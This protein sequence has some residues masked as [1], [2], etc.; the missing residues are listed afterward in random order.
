MPLIVLYEICIWIAWAIERKERRENPELYVEEDNTDLDVKDEDWNKEGIGNWFNG[1][2]NNDDDDNN[3]GSPRADG[4]GSGPAP[5]GSGG[6]SASPI[7]PADGTLTK[8]FG[9]DPY[10]ASTEKTE[11][12][13]EAESA[14]PPLTPAPGPPMAAEPVSP[15]MEMKMSIEKTED[16]NHLVLPPGEVPYSMS[17]EDA[18]GYRDKHEGSEQANVGQ[19]DEKLRPQAGAQDG[20]HPEQKGG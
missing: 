14:P 10:S 4:G 18:A 16:W 17:P 11:P 7:A 1:N 9:G 3:G 13:T 20:E 6:S 2:D 8:P 15:E 5:A 12:P 19:D